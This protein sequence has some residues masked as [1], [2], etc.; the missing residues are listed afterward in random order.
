MPF[1]LNKNIATFVN[2]AIIIIGNSAAGKSTLA[3]SLA[4]SGYPLISDD[5]SAI[6][7]ISGKCA[8]LPGI[9]IV[10]LWADSTKALFPDASFKRVRPQ[11]NKY[12]IPSIPRLEIFDEL[13]VGTIL[14]L[15]TKNSTG[16]RWK[17]LYGANKIT[18]LRDH[19]FRD[20][21][22]AGM[23][24]LDHHFKLLSTLAIQSSLI[25]VERP[26][27]PLNIEALQSFVLGKLEKQ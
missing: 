27:V 9:P 25:N 23:N 24:K 5:L 26:S 11:I 22:M 15:Q 3:T 12:S 17:Q 20:Q 2:K 8:I 16:Y 21:L 10:K 4:Q 13:E 14:N 7:L 1:W 18:V 19:V 6:T